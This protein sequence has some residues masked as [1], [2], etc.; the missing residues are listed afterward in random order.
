MIDFSRNYFE[1]FGLQPRFA[2]DS[3]ELDR[4]YRAL[5]SEVHPDRYAS[6]TDAE[7]RVAMQS[8]ARVNEAYRALRDPVARAA[9][10]LALHGIAEEDGRDTALD[11]DFL[12]RQLERREQASEAAQARD[13]RTLASLLDE[14][15]TEMAEREVALRQAL[16]GD[17]AWERARVQVRE[18]RFLA[19][20]AADL[21]TMITDL[22]A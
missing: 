5:Q 17:G 21:D 13:E 16:D 1:I 15:R 19:K 22:V 20:V 7:R 14:V 18:L 12:E 2:V 11:F 10:I 4:A 3:A 9:H 6:G 8:A